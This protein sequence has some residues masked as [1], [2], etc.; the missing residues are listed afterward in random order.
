[1]A[2]VFSFFVDV[3]ATGEPGEVGSQGKHSFPLDVLN[4]FLVLWFLS[5]VLC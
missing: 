2:S 3:G 4:I 5:P 1:M